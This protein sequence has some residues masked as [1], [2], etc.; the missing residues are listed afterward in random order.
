MID[1]KLN[2]R[3]IL[4]IKQSTLILKKRNFYMKKK[5]T[6]SLLILN[7]VISVALSMAHPVTPALIRKLGLPSFMFGVFFATMSLGNFIFSPIWGGLSDK[8]GRIKYLI[9]GLVGYGISQLGF[10][11]STNTIVIVIFRLLG[12][13]FVTS[14]LTVSIAYLTDITTKE[15]RLKIMSYYAACNTIGSALGSLLGGVIGNTNYKIAFLVQSVLCIVLSIFIYFILSETIVDTGEKV[16]IKLNKIKFN[17]LTN[18]VDTN[19]IM[20]ILMV[21]IFYFSSTSYSS[22]I[23]YY[24]ESILKLPPSFNGVFLSIAGIC[25]F[26]GNLLLTS[27]IGKKVDDK[28]SFK[29]LTLLLGVIIFL[30]SITTNTNLFFVLIIIF[31]TISSIYVPIQQ[32]IVTKLSKDNYGS[33]MGIQ[34]SAKS[35]GMVLGS[36]FAGFIFDFGSKL[37]FMIAGIVLFIGF[38][39]LTRTKID[40]K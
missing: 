30:A 35:M 9:I 12:G 32:N 6:K 24:I 40:I 20:I 36:L 8:K 31:V 15:N 29:Y 3:L 10:G 26:L 7:L 39:I 21:I 33:L 11:L 5:S 19:L 4:H 17:K 25:G 34:N 22:S 2:I 37:P 38:G 1:R 14:Y 23:N 27:Y 28:V 13:A 16:R 18:R